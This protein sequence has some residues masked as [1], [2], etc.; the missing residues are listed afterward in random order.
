MNK[1][2]SKL[3]FFFSILMTCSTLAGQ[4]TLTATYPATIATYD[5]IQLINQQNPN[6]C[7]VNVNG[8]FV[9][10]GAFYV[11]NSGNLEACANGAATP[12]TQNSMQCLNQYCSFQTNSTDI[13]C[14][15]YTSP[16]P[17]TTTCPNG[18]TTVLSAATDT[19]NITY[20][21][22]I[23]NYCIRSVVCCS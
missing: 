19:F 8:T 12:F 14:S 11:D 16:V 1:H 3:F 15:D 6:L 2:I 21:S 4:N 20:F 10:N 18:Y 5:H 9:N 7:A 23:P 22:G 13:N 17:C